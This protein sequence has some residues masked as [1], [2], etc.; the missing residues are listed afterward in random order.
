MVL[1]RFKKL[2]EGLLG[3]LAAPLHSVGVRPNTLTAAG[4]AFSASAAVLIYMHKLMLELLYPSAALMILSGLCDALDGTMARMFG[5]ETPVGGFLDSLLDRYGDAVVICSVILSGLCNPVWGVAALVGSLLVSYAR[6]RGESL[7]VQ[8]A[9]VGLG[10]R[11]ERIIILTAA[12]LIEPLARGALNVAM[13]VLTAL[14]HV[15]VVQRAVHFWRCRGAGG[16]A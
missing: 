16:N 14:T 9:S 3:G 13:I 2:F 11:A 5:E 7:G 6:A 10:E 4:L 8:M 15:T 12:T 1:S